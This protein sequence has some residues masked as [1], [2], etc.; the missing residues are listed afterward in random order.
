MPMRNS[1][2]WQGAGATGNQGQVGQAPALGNLQPR[3]PATSNAATRAPTNIQR[4][5][6]GQPPRETPANGRHAGQQ[7]AA[8]RPANEE[9]ADE[10]PA[11]KRHAGGGRG[12]VADGERPAGETPPINQ[13]ANNNTG[14][15]VPTNSAPMSI[16][17]RLDRGLITDVEGLTRQEQDE[18]MLWAREKGM[19]WKDIHQKFKFKVKEVT[20]R[21][22]DR[23][24]RKDK[25]PRT[26]IFT[27]RD[28]SH[29]FVLRFPSLLSITIPRRYIPSG[30]KD[31]QLM[32]Y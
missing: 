10:Q 4:P 25:P 22:R 9:P 5:A 15:A 13:P 6:G 30:G 1:G 8:K 20:L 31:R 27:E 14:A 16:S 3:N 2:N 26:P 23:I 7:T 11:P 32:C 12:Q 28:V 24:V 21:G 19:K 18:L 29:P 17:E